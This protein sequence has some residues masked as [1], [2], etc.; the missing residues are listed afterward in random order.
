MKFEVFTSLS[1]TQN[2]SSLASAYR[3]HGRY[4]IHSYSDLILL[5]DCRFAIAALR[6][7]FSE[8]RMISAIDNNFL[9][10]FWKVRKILLIRVFIDNR[11]VRAIDRK[12]L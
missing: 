11:I 3:K 4:R 2:R 7:I 12:A 6:A 5:G 8:A 10:A 1:V 9:V